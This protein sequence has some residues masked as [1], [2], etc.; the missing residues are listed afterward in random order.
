MKPLS[1]PE[2][3]DTS[4]SC[5]GSR[6]KEK[7]ERKEGRRTMSQFSSS[8]SGCVERFEGSCYFH[9]QGEVRGSVSPDVWNVSLRK[10][11]RLSSSWHH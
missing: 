11:Q 7:K 4:T 1:I 6:K 5:K 10:R 2:L 9:L 8:S 3:R